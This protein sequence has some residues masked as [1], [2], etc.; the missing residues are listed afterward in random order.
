MLLL[1]LA[2]GLIEATSKDW[3]EFCARAVAMLATIMIPICAT[4]V[5]LIDG[6]PKIAGRRYTNN[7]YIGGSQL[8]QAGIWGNRE[9]ELERSYAPFEGDCIPLRLCRRVR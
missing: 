2:L 4:R 8:S 3:R 5:T 9:R 1:P 6:A 7:R